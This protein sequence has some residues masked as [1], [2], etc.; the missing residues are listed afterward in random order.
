MPRVAGG[1]GEIA[2]EEVGS[3]PPLLFISGT[4]F[5]R[6]AWGGQVAAFAEA[7]RVVEHDRMQPGV[8]AVIGEVEAGAGLASS[9]LPV[10]LQGRGEDAVGGV[11]Q[12][13]VTIA[14]EA[15]EGRAHCPIYL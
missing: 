2:Y 12:G 1:A 6:T 10:G 11:R 13:R 4:S 8:G 3:G 5:D 7:D 15:R 9:V 14:E